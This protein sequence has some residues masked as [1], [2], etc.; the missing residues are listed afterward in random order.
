MVRV[1]VISNLSWWLL[2]QD[3]PW[4]RRLATRST[5]SRLIPLLEGSP[6]RAQAR[7]WIEIVSA[8]D[9]LQLLCPVELG[10]EEHIQEAKKLGEERWTPMS[11]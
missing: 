10:V 8:I 3:D 4:W 6:I 2:F 1:A 7:H 11:D 9:A 5:T